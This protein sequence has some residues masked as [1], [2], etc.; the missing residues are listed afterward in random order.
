MRWWNDV[1]L[2]EGFATYVSYLGSNYTQPEW[3][4]V[5]SSSDQSWRKLLHVSHP[6]K[7]GLVS[8]SLISWS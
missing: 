6:L 4:L 3:G 8:F 2:N 7:A 1:W 5:S